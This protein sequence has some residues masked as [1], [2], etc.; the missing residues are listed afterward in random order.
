MYQTVELGTAKYAKVDGYAI[1]GKLVRRRSFL[2]DKKLHS[3]PFR[4]SSSFKS[5]IVIYVVIDEPQNVDRQD[6]SSIATK[7]ASRIMTELL[8]A[9]GIYP[10][11]EIDYLLPG[12]DDNSDEVTNDNQ[13]NQS[14]DNNA[15]NQ[16]EQN[17]GQEEDTIESNQNTG[18]E[19]NGQDEERPDDSQDEQS[20]DRQEEDDHT[21]SGL[22]Q[23]EEDFIRTVEQWNQLEIL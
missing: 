14:P 20:D 7:F 3:T 5:E 4:C 1:G 2:E 10:E 22:G 18:N 6:N 11:G 12:T 21:E 8:P 19:S 13:P 17:Q 9:L 23:D 15:G 16:D